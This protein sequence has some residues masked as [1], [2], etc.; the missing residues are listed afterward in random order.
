[1][2]NEAEMIEEITN[3]ILGKLKLTLPKDFDDFV[4]MED[5]IAEISSRLRLESEEVKM[6]GIWG[7][8]GIGKTTIARA[9]FN[10]LSC[11]FQGSVFIDRAFVSK[12]RNI[13]ARANPD[14][15]NM[16]LHLQRNF[17]CEILGKRHIKIDHLGAVGERLKRRKVLIV[18]DDLDDQVVLDTLVGQTNWFGSG[19]RIIVVTKDRHFLRSHGIDCVYEVGLPAENLALEMLSR[20]AFKQRCPLAGFTELAVEVANLFGYLPLGLKALGSYLRGRDKESWIMHGLR[21]G[22]N[23]KL[24]EALRVDYEGLGSKKD[25]A[26]FRHIACLLNNVEINDIKLLLEDSGLDVNTGLDNLLDNAL[27]RERWNVV[28]MHC[29]VQEMG[30]EMVRAQSKNPTKRE[31][32]V[33]SKDIC[34]VLGGNVVAEKLSGISLNLS[35]LEEYPLKCLPSSF[36]GED[37][38]VL[39][40]RNSK[41]EKLW[42]GAQSLSL[43]EHMDLRGS[44]WLKEI[45]D[46]SM[47]TNLM[48]L[49]LRGCQSLVELPGSILEWNNLELLPRSINLES[50]YRLDL[51]GCSRFRIFPDISRNISFLILNQTAIEEVPCWIENFS[52]LISLDM[53]GCRKLKRISPNIS[54]MKLLEKADFSNCE[55]LTEASWLDHPSLEVNTHTKLP[56]LNFINCL[57]LEIKKLSFNNQS[58]ST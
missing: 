13:Y 58:S 24:E 26:I 29:L 43:L 49:D 21:K 31:F 22:L 42:N 5:H 1:M 10:R 55:A 53:W 54:K 30:K 50:L 18:L 32:L 25:K 34:D 45:P 48:T 36:R 28:H 57:K 12:S 33:D 4:G 16:R 6:V 14:D 23:K 41:L 56:V 51:G 40:M 19:S 46:L 15:Y 11:N 38:V 17:L 47:A 27:I 8:S 39:K 52:K 9:A 2:D 3:D 20:Y 7:P 35:E 37:L 44:T